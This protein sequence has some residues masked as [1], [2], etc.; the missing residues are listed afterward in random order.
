[1]KRAAESYLPTP[2]P[3]GVSRWQGCGDLPS[4]LDHRGESFPDNGGAKEELRHA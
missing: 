2:A 4:I 1:M 3:R